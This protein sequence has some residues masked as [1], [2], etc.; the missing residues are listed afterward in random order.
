MIIGLIMGRKG[1]KGFPKKNLFP[2][3]GRPLAWY[4]MNAAAKCPEI[5]V[6]YISTDDERLMTIAREHGFEIIVRPPE[7]CTDGALGEAVYIHAYREA[8]A[9]NPGKSID[10]LVLL[11]CN[12][13]M[14]TTETLSKGINQLLINPEYDS[15]I[16]VSRYNMWSPLRA[17]KIDSDGL[18]QPFVPFDFMGDP[19]KLS[20]DRDSQGDVWFA[21]FGVSIIRPRN[22]EHIEEGLLPQKWMGKKIFPLNQEAGCD[23]DYEWQI[24]TVEW[25]LRKNGFSPVE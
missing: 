15:A 10:L 16:T 11:M 21:D 20:C 8:L 7:L 22:L 4:P 3:L 18:L 25:W 24:P 12:A 14:I 23:V 2:I 5:D 1:S 6:S 17:R 19:K 13:P 9:R